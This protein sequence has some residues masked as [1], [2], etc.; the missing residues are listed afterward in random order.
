MMNFG[1]IFFQRKC[2]GWLWNGVDEIRLRRNRRLVLI[3]QCS[4]LIN[5]TG[6]KME[7]IRLVRICPHLR[8]SRLSSPVRNFINLIS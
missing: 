6:Q 8:R 4:A 7:E 2:R 3:P 1:S 5:S